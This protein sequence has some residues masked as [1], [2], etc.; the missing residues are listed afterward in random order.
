MKCG[1]IGAQLEHTFIKEIH[2]MLREDKYEYGYY[3]LDKDET[4]TLIEEGLLDG[5]NVTAPYRREAFSMCAKTTLRAK[6][7]G[8]VNTL[9]RL[10]DGTYY[11]ENTEYDGLV[12]MLNHAGCDCFRRK[13][14]ILG[15]G[16]MAAMAAQVALDMKADKVYIVS[17][18]LERA[19]RLC[20]KISANERDRFASILNSEE[21]FVPIEYVSI[22]EAL[23][24]DIL[25]NAT[26]SGMYPNFD[27]PL[28]NLDKF[29]SLKFVFDLA[30]N[31][32]RTKLVLEAKRKGIAAEGGLRMLIVSMLESSQLFKGLWEDA[33]T[34]IAKSIQIEELYEKV[35][36]KV[37]NY[38]L[39]GMPGCGK[40][41]FA[42][43]MAEDY[44]MKCID[45]DSIIEERME[46]SIVDIFNL[47]GEEEF[48]KKEKEVVEE[49]SMYSGYV[50][51][52][53]GGTVMDEGNRTNLALNGKV[54]Y[55]DRSVDELP[56]AGRPLSKDRDAI[57]ILYEKRLPIYKGMADETIPFNYC[58]QF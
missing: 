17:R 55:I 43:K 18:S 19:T 51:A 37:C 38:V 40:S 14:M 2:E 50:I 25:I 4:K 57:K 31:P 5:V 46:M 56:T 53:G 42:K 49:V 32:Y 9:V 8:A 10:E 3:S 58:A 36:N 16:G 27:E 29:D 34:T 39:I 47:Y 54:I 21:V 20:E 45:T 35:F 26:S 52:T 6:Q 30:A 1:L 33:E 7:I 23:D 13:V 22:D 41:T 44:Q 11:G 48:R 12:Y 15:T 24:V 28:V